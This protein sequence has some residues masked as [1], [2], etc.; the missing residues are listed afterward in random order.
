ML[1]EL[2]SMFAVLAPE[3]NWNQDFDGLAKEFHTPVAEELF[4][5]R[6]DEDDAA[7]LSSH[8]HGIWSG[9]QQS[10]NSLLGAF[11]VGNIP[12]RAGDEQAAIGLDRAEADL[13]RKFA[14][15]LPESIKFQPCTHRTEPRAGHVTSPVA[16]MLATEALRNQD[17]DRL[18]QK[19]RSRVAEQSFC[20]YIYKYDAALVIC[21][22]NAV[23]SSINEGTQDNS[24]VTVVQVFSEHDDSSSR[25]ENRPA[26]KKG[27]LLQ[28]G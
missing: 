18:I 9:I 21:N 26:T 10:K 14:T 5:L 1:H 15:V 3:S 23:G 8:N 24:V 22:N 17:F 16:A 27:G 2:P 4:R 7:V 6:I 25:T 19:L 11:A 13:Y 20:L 28:R 12:D